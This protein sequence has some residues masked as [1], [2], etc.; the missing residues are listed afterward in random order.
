MSETDSDHDKTQEALLVAAKELRATLG[1][2]SIE[3][4]VT[5]TSGDETLRISAGDG[6]WYARMAALRC[7]LLMDEER[8]REFIRKIDSE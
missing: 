4:I 3:I 7:T 1:L 2:N 5:Y 8:T 6:D